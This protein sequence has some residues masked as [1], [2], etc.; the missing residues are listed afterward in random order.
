MNIKQIIKEELENILREEE[1][2]EINVVSHDALS[3]IEKKCDELDTV[4]DLAQGA[5]DMIHKGSRWSAPAV[6]RIAE[7]INRISN[8]IRGLL[9]KH[10]NQ[11][12]SRDYRRDQ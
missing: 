10:K 3:R 6:R 7:E 8:E 5:E 9:V 12:R 2:E 11:S 4:E 1:L